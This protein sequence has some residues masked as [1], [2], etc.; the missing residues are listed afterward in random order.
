MS[1]TENPLD[2][3]PLSERFNR[4]TPESV[5]DAVEAGGHRCTGRFLIL[6]SYENRVYQLQLED[7][8][9][10]VGKFYRPGRWSREAL[11]EEHQFLQELQAEEIPV[12]AP[13]PL[14]G[15]STVGEVEGIYYTLFPRVGGRSPEEPTIEQYGILGRLIARIHNVGARSTMHH[16]PPLTVET[17][18]DENLAI[19]E[20]GDHIHPDARANYVAT[21]K[22][23]LDR[24][25]W[26]FNE[27]PVHRIHGDCH[28][29]NLLW[30]PDGPLFLD[31]DD[32][33]VGPAVQ[34]I[35]MMAA[36]ADAHGARE[37]DHLVGAYQ[38]MRPFNEHW[39]TLVEPLRALRFVHYST[40][41]ARRWSDPI[42][43]KTFNHFG[44]LQYWQREIQD[45][46]EQIARIDDR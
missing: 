45:L 42:F 7:D 1:D 4:L 30:T 39:L 46:R 16:R 44:T 13:L 10:V 22:A 18:G 11:L 32:A 33:R 34:D 27:I 19:L 40:W 5:L 29:S 37:R 3:H 6:N 8:S 17:Y 38:E 43:K 35:W 36:S 2:L 21:V 12:A 26:R 41:I 14:E 15:G 25:R 9:W 23:L 31:F 24:I 28:L 20:S